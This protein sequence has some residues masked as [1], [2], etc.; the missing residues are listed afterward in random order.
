MIMMF[1]VMDEDDIYDVQ[2]DDDEVDDGDDGGDDEDNDE[3]NDWVVLLKQK[4]FLSAYNTSF[5]CSSS[6]HVADLLHIPIP[7]SVSLPSFSQPQYIH[8]SPSLKSSVYS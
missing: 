1:K 4:Q 7:V 3:D 5:F 8:L 2:G 6:F